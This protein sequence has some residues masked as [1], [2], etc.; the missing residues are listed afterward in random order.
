M[1]PKKRKKTV[2]DGMAPSVTERLGLGDGALEGLIVTKPQ[3]DAEKIQDVIQVKGV[4]ELKKKNCRNI[5][6]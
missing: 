1:T 2:K 3:L 6:F 5:R 4:E